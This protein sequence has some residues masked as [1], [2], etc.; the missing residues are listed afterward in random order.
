MDN[1]FA[2]EEML[3]RGVFPEKL[4]SNKGGGISSSLRKKLAKRAQIVK[5]PDDNNNDTQQKN[6]A[7]LPNIG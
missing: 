2:P 1:T 7:R 4:F 6:L 5:P 3:Y